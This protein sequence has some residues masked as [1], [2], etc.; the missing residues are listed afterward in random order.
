MIIKIGQPTEHTYMLIE[1]ELR[2][3]GICGN[4]L[5]G[6]LTQGTHFGLDLSDDAEEVKQISKYDRR[7]KGNFQMDPTDNLNN[8]SLVNIF[9]N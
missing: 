9:T 6:I 2:V 1:G 5:L 8:R 7:L 3:Y 4:E